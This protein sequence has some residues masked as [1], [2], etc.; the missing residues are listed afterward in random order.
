MVLE[1]GHS[2]LVWYD[3]EVSELASRARDIDALSHFSVLGFLS[4]SCCYIYS[5]NETLVDA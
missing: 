1:V 4:V 5:K 2:I 3:F